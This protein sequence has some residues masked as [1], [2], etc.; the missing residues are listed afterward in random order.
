ML[1][2]RKPPLAE[3]N[4]DMSLLDGLYLGNNMR[5]RKPRRSPQG[6]CYICFIAVAT[7]FFLIAVPPYPCLSEQEPLDQMETADKALEEKKFEDAITMYS[8][9]LQEDP[10]NF[11]AQTQLAR[12]YYLAA[13]RNP[14]Y[15]SEAAKEYTKLIQQVPDF[16]FPYLELG[17]IAYL[18]GFTSEAEGKQ[19]HAQGL[20]KSALDW[21]NRYIQLEQKG[22][23]LE[24]QRE[25]I[26][27]KVLQS[28]V[29]N[30]MGESDTARQLITNAQGEYQIIS[31]QKLDIV[32]LFLL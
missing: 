13:N 12:A 25:V 17:Q 7:A 23:T 6:T 15:F 19:K 3:I 16:S 4:R 10:S 31:S 32:S 20:Y 14:D 18:L 30:R 9:I 28:V 8:S 5:I 29:Y 11:A 21:L 2:Y 24:N 27:T 22:E 26:A 1:L